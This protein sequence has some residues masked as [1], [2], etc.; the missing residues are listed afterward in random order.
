[1]EGLCRLYVGLPGLHFLEL[2]PEYTQKVDG[3]IL[4]APHTASD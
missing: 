1:M 3:I 2:C 4:S